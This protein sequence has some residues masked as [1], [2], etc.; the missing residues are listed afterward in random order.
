[1]ESVLAQWIYDFMGF[2]FLYSGAA[3]LWNRELFQAQVLGFDMFSAP[4]GRLIAAIIPLVEIVLGACLVAGGKLLFASLVAAS[5]LMFVFTV[6]VTWAYLTG[7]TF[8]CFCFGEDDGGISAATV[9][10]NVILVC[11]LGVGVWFSLMHSAPTL[12]FSFQ[13]LVIAGYAASSLLI[14]LAGVQL[15]SLQLERPKKV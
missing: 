8:S 5:G 1:M 10:R 11:L 3:K 12:F 6:F 4:L 15:L 9:A 2:I 14:F 13:R 7:R